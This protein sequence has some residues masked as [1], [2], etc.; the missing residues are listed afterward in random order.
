[1]V[2]KKRVQKSN[3]KTNKKRNKNTTQK[4]GKNM[5]LKYIMNYPL[6]QGKR[7]IDR[8]IQKIKKKNYEDKVIL[9]ILNFPKENNENVNLK[10]IKNTR[11]MRSE[12]NK[13]IKKNR[14]RALDDEQV[15]IPIIAVFNEK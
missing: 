9:Y 3:R 13:I 14:I 5:E 7:Y 10:I 1:M 6:D 12:Y 2:T 15:V 11:E 8:Y 4:G